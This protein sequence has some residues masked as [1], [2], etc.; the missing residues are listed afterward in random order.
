[1]YGLVLSVLSMLNGDVGDGTY[2]PIALTFA[3]LL[4]IY[5]FIAAPDTISVWITSLCTGIIFIGAPIFW[6]FILYMASQSR[7]L[8]IRLKFF[9]LMALRYAASIISLLSL[10]DVERMAGTPDIEPVF[11]VVWGILFALG[12]VTI[13]YFFFRSGFSA[14]ASDRIMKPGT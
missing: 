3:P 9:L 12:E 6:G 13:W 11:L 1:M 2:I 5:N 14:G 7:H 4:F 8:R 10:H